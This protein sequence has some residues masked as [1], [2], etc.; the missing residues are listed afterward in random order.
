MEKE[1]KPCP[2]CEADRDKFS[3]D[4]PYLFPSMIYVEGLGYHCTICCYTEPDD[5][6]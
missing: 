2:C 4:T 6:K 5:G 3:E 1:T